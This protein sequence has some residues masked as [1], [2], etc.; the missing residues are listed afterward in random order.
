MT[1]KSWLASALAVLLLTLLPQ[2]PVN[3]HA[4]KQQVMSD[5]QAGKARMLTVTAQAGGAPASGKTPQQQASAAM[6]EPDPAATYALLAAR[7]RMQALPASAKLL[8]RVESNKFPFRLGGELLWQ[9]DGQ[10]YQARTGIGAFGLARVQTSRGHFD[11][12][13][14]APERFA[15]KFRK[16]VAAV[17]N[18]ERGV[19]SF[20]VNAPDLPLQP[21]AQ[22]RLSVLLQL[23]ALVASAPNDFVVGTTVSVQ[24]I[25]QRN[26]EPW[27]FTFG[28]METLALPGGTQ[29]GLKLERRPRKPD[30]Q[31]VE[32]WLAPGLGYLPARLRITEPDGDYADQRWESSQPLVTP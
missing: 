11:T 12:L 2:W 9:H 28:G 13:G 21:G 30:D 25:G 14:L 19:V 23:G 22:D 26:A 17:F 4:A 7:F 10:S 15:D 20:S 31:R 29:I 18:R 8:Y 5:T 27:L 6:R 3:A 32:V 1:L 24:T 16:E